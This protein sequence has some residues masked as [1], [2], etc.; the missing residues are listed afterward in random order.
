M[1]WGALDDDGNIVRDPTF[2]DVPTFKEEYIRIKGEE[3]SGEAWDAWKAFFTAGFPAQKMVFLPDGADQEVIDAYA[4]AFDAVTQRPDF[5]EISQKSLGVYPQ[6]TGAAADV[7]LKLGT[8]VAPAAK[9]FIKSWL[10]EK[11]GVEL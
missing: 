1:T 5:A 2:P 8:Q 9:D 3:P 6:S 4:A 10:K 7:R 11:Y